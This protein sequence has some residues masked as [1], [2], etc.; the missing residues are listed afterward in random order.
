MDNGS[1][2]RAIDALLS[3]TRASISQVKLIMNDMG[4]TLQGLN[5]N[6]SEKGQ[7]VLEDLQT[8]LSILTDL[9][10]R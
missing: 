9:D 6:S 1:T 3:D 2:I 7:E 8:A 10:D 5:I 4:S